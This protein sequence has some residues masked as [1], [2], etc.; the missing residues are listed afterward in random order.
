MLIIHKDL[1]CN[2]ASPLLK[3]KWGNKYANFDV[4][5]R[6]KFSSERVSAGVGRPKKRRSTSNS[7]ERGGT[8]ARDKQA[9]QLGGE[10]ST[11]KCVQE[12][13]RLSNN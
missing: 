4:G 11:W 6:E 3:K 5:A 9:D 1:T 13:E 2:R 7:N 8:L 10:H 12:K